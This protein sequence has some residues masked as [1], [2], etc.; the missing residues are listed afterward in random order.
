MSPPHYLLSN[1]DNLQL[2]TKDI[3]KAKWL[4]RPKNNRGTWYAHKHGSIILWGS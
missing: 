3:F 2:T 1:I 4:L